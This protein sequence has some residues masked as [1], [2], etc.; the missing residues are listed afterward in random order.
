MQTTLDSE[1]PDLLKTVV[2]G[3]YCVGCGACAVV[4]EKIRIEMT[5]LGT[6][7]AVL[8]EGTTLSRDDN[9]KAAAVCGFSALAQNEDQIAGALYSA[10]ATRHPEVGYHIQTLTGHVAEG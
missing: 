6:Y 10:H 3:G 4:S 8:A 9:R 2:A 5:H 1:S 7:Q